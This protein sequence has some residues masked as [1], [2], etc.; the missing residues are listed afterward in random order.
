MIPNILNAIDE[1][2]AVEMNQPSE[3]LEVLKE[4]AKEAI[5]ENDANMIDD[6]VTDCEMPDSEYVDFVA[7]IKKEMFYHDQWDSLNLERRIVRNS[8]EYVNAYNEII[9]ILL[10]YGVGK[11]SKNWLMEATDSD[12]FIEKFCHYELPADAVVGGKW[13]LPDW[14]IYSVNSPDAPI[15]DFSFAEFDGYIES[16]T[17]TEDKDILKIKYRIYRRNSAHCD[18]YYQHW[19]SGTALVNIKTHRRWNVEQS[20][21]LREGTSHDVPAI[22]V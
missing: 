16:V 6:D 2:K 15:W 10:K 20:L 3:W 11:V 8:K 18:G 21:T 7:A 14:Y 13:S 5:C 19:D 12:V 9:N 22:N 4:S 17:E 1:I